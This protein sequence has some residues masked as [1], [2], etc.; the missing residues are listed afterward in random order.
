[1]LRAGAAAFA[2]LIQT[3]I[4]GRKEPV[5]M[6]LYISF[7]FVFSSREHEEFFADVLHETGTAYPP[8]IA[9]IYLLSATAETR[10]RFWSMVDLDGNFVD[11]CRDCWQD[12]DSRRCVALAANLGCNGGSYRELSP[13]Y[14]YSSP[15]A[16]VFRSAVD[17]WYSNGGLV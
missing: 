13:A 16:S 2:A 3:A 1:M 14:L 10:D 5:I 8:N 7:P 6:K 17:Y 15:L 12:L 9:A 4:D 11:D